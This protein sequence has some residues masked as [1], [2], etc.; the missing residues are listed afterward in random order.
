MQL[1][2]I[3][4]GGTS[5]NEIENQ[6]HIKETYSDKALKILIFK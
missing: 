5:M 6:K 1:E 4:N 2:Q 3:L